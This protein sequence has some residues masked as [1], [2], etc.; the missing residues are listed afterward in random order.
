MMGAALVVLIVVPLSEVALVGR[1]VLV[2]A[3]DVVFA[4]LTLAE[5]VMLITVPALLNLRDA[6]STI[7]MIDYVCVP[8]RSIGGAQDEPA[9]EDYQEGFILPASI[10]LLC[11]MACMSQRTQPDHPARQVRVF[12]PADIHDRLKHLAIDAGRPVNEIYVEGA[13]LALRYHGRADGLPQPELP[14][15]LDADDT[16]KE[17]GK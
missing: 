11:R 1:V 6:P 4:V 9:Q 10:I 3:V 2:V 15:G 5:L 8:A 12:V 14:T 13:I 7:R 16:S 17:G